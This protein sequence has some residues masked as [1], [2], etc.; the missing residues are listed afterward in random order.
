MLLGDCAEIL[1][2][3][4]QRKRIERGQESMATGLLPDGFFLGHE[5][6]PDHI[7]SHSGFVEA[8]RARIA[9]MRMT[10]KNR[11][12]ILRENDIVF[13]FVGVA[14]RL[15]QVGLVTE[16][17]DAFTS[18]SLC[19]IRA[20]SID[21]VWLFYFLEEPATK[22]RIL[23]LAYGKKRSLMNIS[24]DD[25]RR[26]EFECPIQSESRSV[27]ALHDEI[28]TEWRYLIGT[29]EKIDANRQKVRAC[30]ALNGTAGDR[31]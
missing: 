29:R 26:F 30:F 27:N 20:T 24:L 23:K 11:K 17:C 14:N 13:C 31:H 18:R 8:G 22:K 2:C 3:Q 5:I 12:Y 7:D 4:I 15:A 6:S 9:A 28:L 19:I 16:K 21:P 1:R 10:L 25:L